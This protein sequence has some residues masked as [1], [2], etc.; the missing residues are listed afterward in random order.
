[1]PESHAYFDAAAEL[2]KVRQL[3]S[4]AKRRR[5]WGKSRLVP[6]RAEMVKLRNAG[7]SFAD[8][9]LWLR[10]ERRIKVVESTVRRYLQKLPELVKTGNGQLS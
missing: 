1:M 2:S 5:T 3:R 4:I 7:A 6:H 9:Q 8:I 10:K